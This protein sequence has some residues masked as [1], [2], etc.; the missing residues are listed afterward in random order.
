MNTT[1]G[2]VWQARPALQALCKEPWPVKTAYQL[3]KL[4]KEINDQYAVI[5]AVRTQ[6]IERYGIPK[7]GGGHQILQGSENWQ[8]FVSDF[9]AL[10]AEEHTIT[11]DVVTLPNSDICIP[12]E[13]LLALDA[14][15]DI[16]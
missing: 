3:A 16:A 15:V 9:N 8:S 11:K 13:I 6:L 4:T 2:A 1:N 10:M 14:F 7:E 12:P 5:E